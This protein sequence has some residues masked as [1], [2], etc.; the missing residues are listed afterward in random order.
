M[1]VFE[2]TKPILS[3]ALCAAISIPL[4]VS[5]A[6]AQS[7]APSGEDPGYIGGYPT[8]ETAQKLYDELDLQRAVEVYLWSLCF[9]YFV[10]LL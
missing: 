2:Q 3:P 8:K 6:H 10:V 1:N 9:G 4:F 5:V 7:E